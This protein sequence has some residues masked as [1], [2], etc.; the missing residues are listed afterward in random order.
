MRNQAAST[1]DSASRSG[2]GDV[3]SANPH[4]AG[5]KF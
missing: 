1:A 5:S 2:M 3:I 4:G